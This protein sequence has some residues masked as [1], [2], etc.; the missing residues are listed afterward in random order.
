MKEKRYSLFLFLWILPLIWLASCSEREYSFEIVELNTHS[1]SSLRAICAVDENTVWAS[2]SQGEVLLS[3]DGGENWKLI[4]VPEC[5]ETEFRSL[6]AWDAKRALVF[7]ISPSGRA[8]MTTDGGESWEQVYSSPMNGAFFNSL[9]FGDADLGI[10]ISDPVD[11]QVYILR[12]TDG[13]HTWHRLETTPPAEDGEINFAASNTCIEY[14]HTGEIF[15]VTGGS[16]ARVL[17][18]NDHGRNWDFIETPAMSGESAG[19]FSVSFISSKKGVAVGGDFSNPD[20]EGNRAIYTEDG[21]KHWLPSESMPAAYRSCVVSFK[22]ELIFA[23]GKTGCDY[24]LDA[25]KNWT[26]IDSAGYYAATIV[27]HRPMIYLSG[28][29][30]KIARVSIHR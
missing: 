11:D 2:G 17:T 16:K 13:G 12:T 27:P 6:H 15:I 21:G 30:G 7:D 19:L 14:L 23:T 18:S 10:A 1:E 8:F 24:S 9:K 3:L 28:S 25:G 22:D 20:L 4:S 5:E 29:Q 26:F